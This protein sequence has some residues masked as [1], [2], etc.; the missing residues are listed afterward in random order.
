MGTDAPE[1][2]ELAATDEPQGSG[3][4]LTPDAVFLAGEGQ[5]G[6]G[7]HA[8]AAHPPLDKLYP[9]GRRLTKG[10]RARGGQGQYAGKE[11]GER[12]RKR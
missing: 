3:E 7:V 11:R 1:P 6:R 2:H 8:D 5:E 12:D 10:G 9:T 4:V